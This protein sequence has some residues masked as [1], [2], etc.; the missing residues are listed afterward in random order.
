[1]RLLCVLRSSL[2]TVVSSSR[3]FSNVSG[4]SPIRISSAL[5]QANDVQINH[6]YTHIKTTPNSARRKESPVNVRAASRRQVCHAQKRKKQTNKRFFLEQEITSHASFHTCP[7]TG[8]KLLF[9]GFCFRWFRHY[10]TAA[11][12]ARAS[13]KVVAARAVRIRSMIITRHC[14]ILLLTINTT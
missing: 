9:Q 14:E 13:V 7:H 11:V 2:S 4:L 12:G 5:R 8:P 6:T 1:M 10:A 3:F